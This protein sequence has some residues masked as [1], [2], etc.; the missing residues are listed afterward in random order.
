MPVSELR[1]NVN[2]SEKKQMKQDEAS[3]RRLSGRQHAQDLAR[4][5]QNPA[6]RRSGEGGGG[7]H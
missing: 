3:R 6:T 4:D 5:R 2:G 1:L 7:S